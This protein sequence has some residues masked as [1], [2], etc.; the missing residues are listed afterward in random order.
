MLK[1]IPKNLSP[2]L[3]KL[4][5]EMGHGDSVVF[6]DAN[7]PAASCAR[8]LVRADGHAIPSLLESVL[9]LFPLDTFTEYPAGVMEVV[10]G[11]PTDPT[12]WEEYR[13]L[14][15]SDPAFPGEFELIPRFSF[16]ERSKTAFGVIAT[17]E[18]A[19]YANL[20]LTKGIIG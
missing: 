16:Y 15:K 9:L 14:L 1:G 20:I 3:L 2:D 10:A 11:D 4:L 17:G 19:L 13:A 12:I 18:T 5:M 6:A 8:R 7:F